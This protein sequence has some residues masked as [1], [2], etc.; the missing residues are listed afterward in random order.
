MSITFHN[1]FMPIFN[2]I[3]IKTGTTQIERSKSLSL[4]QIP[5][6]LGFLK[7]IEVQNNLPISFESFSVQQYI[8]S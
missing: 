4:I 7:I 8:K 3:S 2:N 6:S 5:A 1:P